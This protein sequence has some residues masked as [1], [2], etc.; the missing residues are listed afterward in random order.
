[1]RGHW[2]IGVGFEAGSAACLL[3]GKNW[4]VGGLPVW[5]AALPAPT[6]S[7]LRSLSKGFPWK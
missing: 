1:M 5:L 2:K 7:R 4:V 3:G 6:I